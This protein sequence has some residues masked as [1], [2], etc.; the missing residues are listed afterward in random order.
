MISASLA[1]DL[2]ELCEFRHVVRNI[3]PTRLEA[4]RVR[5]NLR[6]LIRATVANHQI[7]RYTMADPMRIRA[8]AAGDKT[9][10]VTVSM[11]Q[12]IDGWLSAEMM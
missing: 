12:L 7:R 5:E 10:P 9:L 2:L 3:Y 4:P 11:I 8:Q 6:R 1:D